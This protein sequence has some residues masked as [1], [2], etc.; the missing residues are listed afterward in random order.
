MKTTPTASTTSSTT[1]PSTSATRTTTA[2]AATRPA[3]VVDYRTNV[4]RQSREQK[5]VG[6][7]LSIL[8]YTLIGLFVVGASLAGYGAYV[9]TKQLDQQ[10]VT[11]K[12]FDTRYAADYK[13]INVKLATTMDTLGQAQAQIGRQQELIVKQQETINKLLSA[14]EDNA[15]AI[16][17]ER[18]A[19][20]QDTANIKARLKDL[21]YTGPSTRKY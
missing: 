12:D 21:E 11:M 17:L 2:A 16:K 6:G 19:R 4:E 15:A 14:A 3:S 9:V 10:S 20:A 5:S 1:A 8:V 7:I 18:S 13:D